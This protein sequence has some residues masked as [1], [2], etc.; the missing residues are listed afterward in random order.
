M[1]A[2]SNLG[3]RGR[4]LWKSVCEGLPDTWE[5]DERETAILALAARQ[6]D[7][8]ARLESAIKKHGTM[9]KGSAGQSV[10]NPAIAE[11][12]QARMSIGRLLGQLA[13]PD[14]ESEPR[15]EASKRARD[16]ANVRWDLE[17]R[18]RGEA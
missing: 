1:S 12:R 18:R 15:T 16:A 6:S 8:L 14:E 17:R 13:L 4:A 5:L 3:P 9:V 10:L 11:A 2:P 7:D